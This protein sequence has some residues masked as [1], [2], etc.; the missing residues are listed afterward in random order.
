M[1]FVTS[2]LTLKIF[3]CEIEAMSQSDR[4]R[5]VLWDSRDVRDRDR[6]SVSFLDILDIRLC[7]TGDGPW[8]VV[9]PPSTPHPHTRVPV[10]YLSVCM[11]DFLSICLTVCLSVCLLLFLCICWKVSYMSSFS[12]DWR[13]EKEKQRDR[14]TGTLL[15]Q[16]DVWMVPYTCYW[17]RLDKKCRHHYDCSTNEERSRRD[18][19]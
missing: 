11:S 12:D 14:E 6:E 3:I 18:L 5:L 1:S 13:R 15:R 8:T 10:V 7:L 16:F 2:H 9:F 17:Q 4:P 19:A